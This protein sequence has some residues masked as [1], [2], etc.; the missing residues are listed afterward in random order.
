MPEQA[1]LTTF[2]Q[3]LYGAAGLAALIV[4]YL[5]PGSIGHDPWRGDDIRHFMVV[6]DVLLGDSFWWPSAVREPDAGYGPLYYWVSALFGAALGWL[7]PLH[8]ATRLASPFF[9][10]LAIFWVARTAGRLYG[11]H[12][13][14]SAA[15]L[16]LGTL[17]LA[18]HAHEHQP[19]TAIIAAQAMT[20]AGLALLSTQTI[21]GGIQ[22][23]VGC[24]LAFLAG[25]PTALLLTLPLVALLLIGCSDCRNRLTIMSSLAGLL[26]TGIICAIWMTGLAL[27]EPSQFSKWLSGLTYSSAPAFTLQDLGKRLELAAWSAWPLWPIA[28]WTIWKVRK[29]LADITWALPLG[30]TVLALIWIYWHAAAQASSYLPLIVPLALFAAAGVPRLRRGAANAF[31]WF[32]LMTFGSFAILV[33][34]AWSAQAFDWPPGLTRSLQRM[35]PDFLLHGT[36]LQAAFGSIII[37]SWLWL[38]WHLPKSPNR[39]SANWAMGM[40]MLWCLAVTLLMPWFENNR[41]YRAAAESLHSAL[42][43]S[44]A[45]CVSA[46]GLD[47]SHRAAFEYF[48]DIR[49]LPHHESPSSCDHLLIQDGTPQSLAPDDG[50]NWQLVWEF[51]HAGGK[52]LERFELYRFAQP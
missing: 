3:Q 48:S 6:R 50:N 43:L 26:L 38:V 37:L 9:T 15:L 21:K 19:L 39:A 27:N 47:S 14:T 22:A 30:A 16:T 34:L 8:D 44:E 49:I 24:G 45:V 51:N 1:K 28:G 11:R 10:G 25:G 33:W 42:Q 5:L 7:L 31:D 17:G 4:L 23:G 46:R 40:T 35:A 41:S 36:G 12:T 32:A 13:R 29:Q 2:K 52:R 18:I 20:F